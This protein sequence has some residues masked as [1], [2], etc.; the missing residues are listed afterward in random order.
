MAAA[1]PTPDE[2][3]PLLGESAPL[4]EELPDPYAGENAAFMS[5]ARAA[6]GTDVKATALK[7]AIT[8]CLREHGL[9]GG[10]DDESEEPAELEESA[11]GEGFPEL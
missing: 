10:L 2:L 11:V 6:V 5:A 9:I 7:D 8:E 4:D 3:G 1:P